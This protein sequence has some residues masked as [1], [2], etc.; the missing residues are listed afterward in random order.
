MSRVTGFQGMTIAG[1][2]WGFIVF[3]VIKIF[4]T[5]PY[6]VSLLGGFAVFLIAFLFRNIHRRSIGSEGD[7]LFISDGDD[8]KRIPKDQ[9]L[10]Y[11]IERIRSLNL[12]I[13]TRDHEIVSVPINGFFSEREI[14]RVFDSLGIAKG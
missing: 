1:I 13:T 5:P 2:F 14:V 3:F 8:V 7:D 12:R 10:F 9:I 11:K 6:W 4:D